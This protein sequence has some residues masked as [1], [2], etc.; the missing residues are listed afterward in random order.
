[1]FFLL[2]NWKITLALIVIL[3][4]YFA[5]YLP[6]CTNENWSEWTKA[7]SGWHY[8]PLALKGAVCPFI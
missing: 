7:H 3:M 4:A 2:M 8:I 6:S 5:F 1:M